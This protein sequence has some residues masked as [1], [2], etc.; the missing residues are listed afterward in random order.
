MEFLVL[1][2]GSYFS[3]KL[4]T[5]H[6]GRFTVEC[7]GYGNVLFSYFD[8][9]I[10]VSSN[11][12]LN[13]RIPEYLHCHIVCSFTPALSILILLNSKKIEKKKFSSNPCFE[14]NPH[15]SKLFALK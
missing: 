10:Y 12:T 14:P 2:R 5:S 7:T 6:A 9:F 1:I 4:K 15:C 3:K 13:S 11:F 8:I